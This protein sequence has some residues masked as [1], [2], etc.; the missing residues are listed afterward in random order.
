ME[1]ER[2]FLVDK[3]LWDAFKKPAPLSIQQGYLS[4]SKDCTVR[5]RT[6][7]SHAFITVK[8]KTTGISREEFE[9]EIPFLDG[10][11]MLSLLCDKKIEKL[12]YE[13]PYKGKTWEIDVFQGKLVP[14]II[15][16]LE[17]ESEDEFFEKPSFI[18]EDVS[19]NAEYYN[20]VLIDK[21]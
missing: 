3:D 1:I 16:E 2:K 15:A 17:L 20:A 6:K 14:L 4:K 12:R 10:Q 13:V 19:D 7:G 11:E 8:G 18:G 5:V 9:Y 21:L